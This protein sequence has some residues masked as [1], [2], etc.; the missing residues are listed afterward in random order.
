MTSLIMYVN[1]L[2]NQV[3][4]NHTNNFT[5]LNL[6]QQKQ[7]QIQ[8]QKI[9]DNNLLMIKNVIQQ[10]QYSNLSSDFSIC[11]NSLSSMNSASNLNQF[12]NT[13]IS[14]ILNNNQGSN[15][16]SGS[17]SQNQQ[18]IQQHQQHIINS[19][20]LKQLNSNISWNNEPKNFQAG[21][22]FH[23]RASPSPPSTKSN[24]NSSSSSIAIPS[25][26]STSSTPS[27]HL[28]N[29]QNSSS[30]NMQNLLN[31]NCF[32]VNTMPSKQNLI[33][34]Q[35]QGSNQIFTNRSNPTIHQ[36]FMST[37]SLNTNYTFNNNTNHSFN[38]YIHYN[39]QWLSNN[40]IMNSINPLLNPQPIGNIAPSLLPPT[41][42]RFSS[43]KHKP[44]PGPSTPPN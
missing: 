35:V 43:T 32:G 29:P 14:N 21:G 5:G 24:I 10:Q 13:N 41:I 9:N 20:S 27:P 42:G 33:G 39:Q 30:H 37:N 23:I 36:P 18:F 22:G 40:G 17:Y 28:I 7:Q 11:T 15:D 8:N 34:P 19:S 4:A 2:L 31:Y 38:N 25:N 44:G 16:I 12:H 1:Q 26:S 3:N 6:Q